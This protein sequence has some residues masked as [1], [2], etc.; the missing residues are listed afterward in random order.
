MVSS[1]LSA[2]DYIYLF[3][4]PGFSN[5]SS[6]F[7]LFLT[8]PLVVL[9]QPI[10]WPISCLNT[11]LLPNS[12]QPQYYIIPTKHSPLFFQIV[13]CMLLQFFLFLLCVTS[14]LF[15]YQSSILLT[16]FTLV[17]LRHRLIGKAV[18]HY[19]CKNTNKLVGYCKRKRI[20]QLYNVFL[21]S[22]FTVKYCESNKTNQ[23][24]L[25]FS[26]TVHSC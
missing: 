5:P 26:S 2:S 16:P 20:K 25:Y 19:L 24:I 13:F 8:C 4:L 6:H 23:F 15:L 14:W 9:P 12:F 3:H 7:P 11:W 22:K 18:N 17:W 21:N 1:N 10:T